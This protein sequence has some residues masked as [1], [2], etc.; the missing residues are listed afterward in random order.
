MIFKSIKKAFAWVSVLSMLLILIIGGGYV[1]L[2]SSRVQTRITQYI[3]QY[4]S[5][6]LKT[7]VSVE[8]VDIGF[9][10]RVI[11][12]G[13]YVQDLQGDTLAYLN[14]LHLG[15]RYVSIDKQQLLLDKVWIDDLKFYLHK[16]EGEG[17]LNIQFL[18]DYFSA[19]KDTTS[20]SK[21]W[22]IRSD[23]LE[24]RNA[25]F[26][27]INYNAERK[28]IGI[29]YK[30]L[31][32]SRINLLINDIRLDA[33]TIYGNVRKLNCFERRGFLLKNF[34]GKAKVSPTE[35][36]VDELCISTLESSLDLDLH[37]TYNRWGDYINFVDSVRMEYEFRESV[38]NLK[39][40][41]FF[42]PAMDGLNETLKLKGR[43]YGPV[44]SLNAR[45]LVLGYG[46]ATRL[47]GNIDLDG[48]P[49][50]RE[51]FLHLDLKRLITNYSDLNKIPLPPFNESKTLS[52]PKNLSNLG[53]IRF[54]GNFTGFINDFV[55]FGKL[56]TSIGSLQTDIS[57]KQNETTGLLAYSGSLSSNSF[58]IGRFLGEERVGKV[59]LS[60]EV[61]GSGLS[62]EEINARLVGEVQAVE[63]LGYQYQNIDV[64]GE[65]ARS[66]FSGEISVNDT[67]LNLNFRGGFDLSQTLPQF[68]F[69]ADLVHA[70]LYEM[71]LVKKRE[72]ATVSG[73]VDV[74]FIG[75]DIDNLVG[76]I[77]ITDATYQQEGDEKYQVKRFSLDVNEGE[78]I[79][80]LKL[81][82]GILDADFNG[83]FSFRNIPK[84]A[85]NL[86]RKHLPSYAGDFK[87]LDTDRPLEFDFSIDLKNTEV[88]SYFLAPEL[89]ISDSSNFQGRY[90]SVSDQIYLRGRLPEMTY[91]NIRMK[92]VQVEA[93]N[94]GKDFQIGIFADKVNLADS[95]YLARFEV[96]SFTFNDSLGLVVK[97]DNR[98]KIA[99]KAF[100]Q[101]VAS[102][103]KNEEVSFHLEQSNITVAGLDW[104]VE[105]N[106]M[107]RIDTNAFEFT[108]FKFIND[109]QSIGVNGKI[110]KD[111]NAKLD[112]RLRN[113]DLA[114]FNLIT[115]PKGLKLDGRVSGQAQLSGIY[116][117]FFMTNQLEVDSLVV[118]SVS[119]GS[120]EI[121]NTWIPATRSVQVF[122][123]L[124]RNDNTSLSVVGEFLPGED[125]RENF[126]LKATIDQLPLSVFHPYIDKV[127][128]DVHGTAKADVTLKGTI[129]EPKLTG[130][131]VLKD[132]DLMFTYLNTRFRLADTVIIKKDGFYFENLEVLDERDKVAN[133]N[134]WVKH[135]SFKNFIFDARLDAVD[136]M[137]LNTNSAMNTLYYGKGFG[138]GNVRFYGEPKN[139]HLDVAM[140]TER[141]TRF[142]IPLFG[143]K[144]VNE[145]DFVTF[146]KPKGTE[147]EKLDLKDEFKVSFQN[148][149]L[150]MD[151]E[152]TSD[153]EIQLIFDPKVGDI[154][155]GRGDGDITMTLDRSGNFKMFGDYYIKKGEYLFT[156]Q[157][158]INKKFLI[159]QGGTINWSGSPYDAL[160]DITGNY[161]VRTS[162]YELMYPDTS[163][164][165]Y[166]R[167]I[168]VDCILHM[169]GN[170]LNPNIAFDVDL[171]NSDEQTKTEVR[172]RIGVGNDQEM[173]RQVFGLLVLNRFF[174]TETQNQALQQAGGFFSSSSA[175]MIS[176]QLSNWL[177]KISND[178]DIGINYRPGDDI[179]SDEL[180]A[181]LST[182]LFNNRI[183]VD[184]NVGVAN[185]QSSSS[186]I[187]GDVNIEYKITSDGRFRV[188]A[189][190]KSNDINT[191]TNN[192]P[193]TQ[194]I[195]LSYQKEF[196]KI[197]DL[198]KRKKKAAN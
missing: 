127:I 146:V 183:I 30:Y 20:I 80:T 8:G 110:S 139:M 51:T 82:S 108:D 91:K 1:A 111:P 92:G 121:N 6:E 77:E 40:V 37:Y 43:I 34:Q 112:V 11:L 130:L 83:N 62:K 194:G 5:D 99:N 188:R 143:A 18:I 19:P 105:E 134:G 79:K 159:Q 137:A 136:F 155:K 181:S 76:L 57:L 14:D 138:T 9:F 88:V 162:L 178:F 36:K 55:A 50:I 33:D 23:A 94:P 174:P 98:T 189:F 107:L 41:A 61:Q 154:I 15:L 68:N 101:G 148:L 153:A 29:D 25:S 149:T 71:K 87:T 85:N 179:T 12:E 81:R 113:F 72:N 185:T 182:Q 166:K 86:L 160:I 119:I 168:Q 63:L 184:G 190:N 151:I 131:A 102:F 116:D 52:V 17:K 147:D 141:G 75:D 74:D 7:T 56:N 125:R 176:N 39:D 180:Q 70:N 133:V 118:N 27:L 96:N 158:I 10:N 186:N 16:Y 97:W 73:V 171:P 54:Q 177:S 67:N 47:E 120:G 89:S 122:G 69:H 132:A 142:F 126:N 13:L 175:E 53:Q 169:T 95:I 156:L 35:L 161:G 58:D 124:S 59:T 2:R 26:Q 104:T 192:A 60:A 145:T 150:E 22:D 46:D 115:Q 103:P 44:S 32:I 42:A 114:N 191:L 198:F 157:N 170:L 164:D 109:K 144:N 117:K 187:V 106:N 64:N 93:E 197:S 196:N 100:I 173:N 123:L 45:D 21:P 90:S 24:L 84:A 4:L 135:E 140:K 152:V 38:V 128:S 31:E 49:N 193:F 195:G 167:R 165:N 172:N 163:N 28:A 48:L 129:K 3:A 78:T 65:F 66:M